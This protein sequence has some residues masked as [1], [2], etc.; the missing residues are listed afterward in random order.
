MDLC[1]DEVVQSLTHRCCLAVRVDTLPSGKLCYVVRLGGRPF[2]ATWSI[3]AFVLPKDAPPLAI[4]LG[5]DERGEHRWVDL[6]DLPHL[7]GIGATG[8]GKSNFVHAML[9]TWI[10][11]NGP[12]QVQ[13]WLADHKGGVEL[14]RYKALMGSRQ[15]AGIVRRFSYEPRETV[16][17]LNDAFK[18][19][20]RR[21]ASLRGAGA[22][23]I[24]EYA[25]QT[26][27]PMPRIVLVID[28][29]FFLMLSK[30]KIDPGGKKGYSISEWANDLFSKI[31]SAGRAAGVHL[32][33][34]TQKTG[35][36]V[37]NGLITANFE[38]RVVFSLADQYQSITVLGNA[39]AKGLPKGRAV[40]RA[41]DGTTT[42][43]QTPRITSTQVNLV[44][45]R[46]RR[47][48]PD[49]GLGRADSA[50]R[51]RDDAKLLVQVACDQMDGVFAR[52]RMLELEGVKGV[53]S[54][55][56][57]N[58]IAQRLEQDGILERG[59]PRKPRRVARGYMG[60]AHLLD[61]RYG[62]PGEDQAANREQTVSLQ[63]SAGD[64]VKDTVFE[65]QEATNNTSTQAENTVYG[66]EDR[67]EGD[68]VEPA[69]PESN[70]PDVDLPDFFRRAVDQADKNRKQK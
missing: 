20:E 61:L 56:R 41:A 52:G 32:C 22:T 54:A 16:A 46:V 8:N 47:Y 10:D 34:F 58:Q 6:A 11:R 50:R 30:E 64:T 29:I 48:G 49:G 62:L 26:G 31:A 5:I 40:F 4:P 21:L 15:Q 51:F 45:S 67:G 33:I 63:P 59:G 38:A 2:P 55:E 17:M 57:F 60:Q 24:D 65:H 44:I 13:L 42:V 37:L 28:E 68:S 27:T 7:L 36:D 19:L 9:S 14:D 39:A 70:E 23:D 66:M 69:N 35:K 53:V 12:D 3:G 43:I 18:E 1:T 25:R